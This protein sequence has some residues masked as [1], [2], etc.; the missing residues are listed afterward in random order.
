[1]FSVQKYKKAYYQKMKNNSHFRELRR[2]AQQKCEQTEKRK[3]Y[4]KQWIQQYRKN[5][6]HKL[7]IQ[8]D[9][10]RKSK[11]GLT[12]EIVQ[13]VYE[14]NIKKYGTLTCYL[15]E[16]P[17]QFGH[18]HLEHKISLSKGGTS[19]YY[20]LAVACDKCNLTK[21]DKSVYN[22]STRR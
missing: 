11:I 13:R 3:I 19:E 4:K 5:N 18:D 6:P 22:Y 12:I 14:D 21:G 9:R 2:L 15:C 10:R 8:N 17:I 20:N 7:R 1:M 16:I